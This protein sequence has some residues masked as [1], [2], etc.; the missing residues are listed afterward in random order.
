MQPHV[1][2]YFVQFGG[3]M[4]GYMVLLFGSVWLLNTQELGVVAR[5]ALALLP[6][7]PALFGLYAVVVFYRAIDEF[8]KRV[9]SEAMLIA[10]L[11]VGFG[12][13]A[14]G[15]L[16]GALDLPALPL[17]WVFPVM[18]GLYGLTA[19]VLKWVYR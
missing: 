14:Y 17:I 18:I 13:F 4:I 3:S 2:R 16:E 15:F 12:T 1:K 6:V 19:C 11:L 5:G 10:A 9:I 8:Q 7:I